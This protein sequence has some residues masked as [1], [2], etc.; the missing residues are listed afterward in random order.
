MLN[1]TV[2]LCK[3]ADIASF[4][5]VASKS[6]RDIFAISGRY[7]INAKSIMGLYSLD[8]SKPIT[9]KSNSEIEPEIISAL[10]KFK[11]N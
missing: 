7:V 2:S 3:L 8:L 1:M 9:I 6:V 11:V 4:V 10:E 5:N